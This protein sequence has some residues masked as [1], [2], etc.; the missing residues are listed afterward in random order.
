MGYFA[1]CLVSNLKC[2]FKL[3]IQLV[4]ILFT[5]FC[6]QLYFSF[7][8]SCKRCLFIFI[9]RLSLTNHLYAL[10]IYHLIL[11]IRKSV[12][13]PSSFKRLRLIR[14]YCQQWQQHS[15]SNILQIR[16]YCQSC[17]HEL[18]HPPV[19]STRPF[20]Y[21]QDR[22]VETKTKTQ[23]SSNKTKTFSSRPSQDFS[24]KTN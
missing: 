5:L 1:G 23:D 6:L 2:T 8:F 3:G 20:F 12:K 18:N 21:D 13:L 22:V 16:V 17:Y 15:D 9:N 7:I 14:N 24:V 4:P 10:Y 11:Y 19:M